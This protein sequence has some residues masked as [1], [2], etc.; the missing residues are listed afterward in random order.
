MKMKGTKK[1]SNLKTS[2][3]FMIMNMKGKWAYIL[4]CI[5]N[6]SKHATV[7]VLIHYFLYHTGIISEICF[8]ILIL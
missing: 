6:S 3:R 2:H 4:E 5:I 8:V 7:I 1:N